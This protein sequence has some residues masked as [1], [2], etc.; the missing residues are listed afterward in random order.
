MHISALQHMFM[1]LCVCLS[2]DFVC[3]QSEKKEEA[4]ERNTER[5]GSN[6]LF[7]R[8]EQRDSLDCAIWGETVPAQRV[9]RVRKRTTAESVEVVALA[10]NAH[11]G[12]CPERWFSFKSVTLILC[13]QSGSN[14]HRAPKAKVICWA[15]VNPRFP[16]TFCGMCTTLFCLALICCPIIQ[17][18]IH[19]FI[20]MQHIHNEGF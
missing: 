19:Y 8:E 9:Q 10:T 20:I 5:T 12:Q 1:S 13:P 2:I 18:E 11:L 7:H 6:C 17:F 4:R 14:Y 15:P 16:P 3:R